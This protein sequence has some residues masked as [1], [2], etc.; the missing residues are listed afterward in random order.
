MGTVCFLRGQPVLFAFNCQSEELFNAL[1]VGLVVGCMLCCDLLL[2]DVVAGQLGGEHD[3]FTPRVLVH[4]VAFIGEGAFVLREPGFR[5]VQPFARRC[6][7]LSMST[8]LR[9]SV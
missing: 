8:N 4:Q 3:V 1:G 6:P 2:V 7:I 9:S 5:G